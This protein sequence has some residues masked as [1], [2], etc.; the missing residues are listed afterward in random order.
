MAHILVVD[1][2]EQMRG[3]L[4]AMLGQHDHEVE[5]AADGKAAL[6]LVRRNAPDLVI[7]DIVMPEKEGIETIMTIRGD[8]PDLPIIAISGGGQVDGEC[9]LRMARKLGATST[10][11]KPFGPDE[12]IDTVQD[13]LGRTAPA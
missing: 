6:A 13:V 8:F 1:D 2:D 9:Y 11:A 12:L 7:T 5:T 10:L 4:R 3:L